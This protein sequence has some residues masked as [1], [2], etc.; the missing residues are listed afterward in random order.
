MFLKKLYYRWR[1]MFYIVLLFLLGQFYFMYKGIETMPFFLMHMYSAP[2]ATL[3][4]FHQRHLFINGKDFDLRLLSDR[5]KEM[6]MGSLNYFLGLRKS[7]FF[8]T[9]TNSIKKRFK[10]RLPASWYA[11]IYKNL[12]NASITDS[13]YLDWWCRYASKVCSQKVN[14][15]YLINTTIIWNS[16]IRSIA[17]SA[18]IIKYDKP[19][20]N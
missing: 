17:D 6:L 1:F 2:N 4:S 13:T 10:D 9:D 14:S 12:T 8:A 19:K 20:R 15:F 7:N 18:L 16:S 11:Y 3:S 5:E